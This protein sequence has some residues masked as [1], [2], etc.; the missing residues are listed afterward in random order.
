MLV[1]AKGLINIHVE[2]S[3]DAGAERVKWRRRYANGDSILG[4]R[5]GCRSWS[6]WRWN[7]L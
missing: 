2:N 6:H 4:R 3:S 5:T 7:S 1:N